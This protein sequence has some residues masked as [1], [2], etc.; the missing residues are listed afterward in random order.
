MDKKLI[1]YSNST[2]I[3]KIVEWS[4]EDIDN[5]LITA[6]DKKQAKD[7]LRNNVPDLFIIDKEFQDADG[8][9]LCNKIKSSE[10]YA[11]IPVI[12]L[13]RRDDADLNTGADLSVPE[14]CMA[15]EVLG[16]PFDSEE[17]KNM[18]KD[19]L[20]LEP[21]GSD[22]VSEDILLPPEDEEIPSGIE[23]ERGQRVIVK[24]PGIA[25]E[26]DLSNMAKTDEILFKSGDIE[27]GGLGFELMGGDVDAEAGFLESG[28][29]AGSDCNEH[30]GFEH[31]VTVWIKGI[32]QKE[33]RNIIDRIVPKLTKEIVQE[34]I[35]KLI[36]KETL[37][38]ITDQNREYVSKLMTDKAPNIVREVTE[39]IV[40]DLAERIIREEIEHIKQGSN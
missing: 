28:T 14:D 29:E 9:Y 26:S 24:G 16:V 40:P 20:N 7:I 31:S 12:L 33:I 15:D 34:Q 3:Q 23:S 22:R 1:L 39:K 27:G 25:A 38:K 37:R 21:S 8:I 2:T 13:M 17:L 11:D 10:D 36:D 32:I 5:E 19:L 6:T 35:G 4:L 30:S 18:V